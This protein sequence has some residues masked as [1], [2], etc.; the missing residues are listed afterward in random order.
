ME[1]ALAVPLASCMVSEILAL[2]LN[3]ASHFQQHG[4]LHGPFSSQGF[5]LT[6]ETDSSPW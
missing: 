6:C 5:S 1:H 3:A 2:H 4:F